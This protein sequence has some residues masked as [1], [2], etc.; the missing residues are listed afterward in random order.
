[1]TMQSAT[2]HLHSQL[3]R[4]AKGAIRAWEQ[5]L[6]VQAAA[7]QIDH[8]KPDGQSRDTASLT[9]ATALHPNQLEK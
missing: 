1:M 3:I 6:E 5:W 8:S 9:K 4:F 7:P 2:Y